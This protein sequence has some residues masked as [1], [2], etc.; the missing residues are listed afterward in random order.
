MCSI[1]INYS[2]ARVL[3]AGLW[4]NRVLCLLLHGTDGSGR[5]GRSF[6]LVWY[7]ASE[8]G[9]YD[10]GP[11]YQQAPAPDQAGGVLDSGTS[12]HERY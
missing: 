9:S 3:V 6:R 8:H 12:D 2:M 7:P 4:I 11:G 1:S 5:H 10:S